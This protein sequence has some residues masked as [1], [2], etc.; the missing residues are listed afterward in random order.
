MPR[1]RAYPSFA[2]S[3]FR[4]RVLGVWP[5]PRDLF[6]SRLRAVGLHAEAND[7]Q[8]AGVN[9]QL[10][11]SMEGLPEESE[12]ESPGCADYGRT[13]NVDQLHSALK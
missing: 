4:Y 10:R 13:G 6:Q 7:V 12:A 1:H 2:I 9:A 3:L 5:P 11:L 8:D